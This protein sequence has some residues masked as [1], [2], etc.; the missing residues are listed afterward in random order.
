MAIVG[1][2]TATSSIFYGFAEPRWGSQPGAE[3]FG[4]ANKWVSL[5]GGL[6]L[7]MAAPVGFGVAGFFFDRGDPRRRAAFGVMEEIVEALAFTGA[8][9][10][11]LKFAVGR[12]RP[13]GSRYSFPSGHT[14]HAFAAAGV[15]AFH[16]PLYVGLPALLAAATVGFV[17]VDV[18]KHF[19]SDVAAG[20]GIG[21]MYATGVVLFHDSVRRSS[22]AAKVARSLT[23]WVGNGTVGLSWASRF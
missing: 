2:T 6:V 17:R 13:D 15:I 16:S 5:F 11:A 7:P 20:A 19:Y 3:Y 10:L 22:D 23:P 14:S 18:N 9:T 8:T 4:D 21:L 12:R 1:V